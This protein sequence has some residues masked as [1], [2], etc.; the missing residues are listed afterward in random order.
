MTDETDRKDREEIEPAG[1]K[2]GDANEDGDDVKELLSL[3]RTANRRETPPDLLP[4]V[5]KKIRQRSR[6]KFYGDGWS[7]SKAHPSTYLITSLI[8]LVILLA[9]YFTMMPGGPLRTP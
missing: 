2:G 8:M 7:T 1:E 9:I 4:G 6:G 3:L 5:Q